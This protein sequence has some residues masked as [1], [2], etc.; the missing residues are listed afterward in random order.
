MEKLGIGYD[1]LRDVNPRIILAST[2]G[3]AVLLVDSHH[4]LTNVW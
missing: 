3:K 4:Y 2:S 1:I